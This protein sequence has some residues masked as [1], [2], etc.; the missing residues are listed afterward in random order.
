MGH[1]VTVN[2]A[3]KANTDFTKLLDT[4]MTNGNKRL[5]PIKKQFEEN[6]V[7]F[8]KPYGKNYY[9]FGSGDKWHFSQT[10]E[11]S[12][13]SITNIINGLAQNIALGIPGTGG[14]EKM[15]QDAKEGAKG[16][17][18]TLKGALQ[19]TNV[20]LHIAQLALGVVADV[21]DL[22]DS[23]V[24]G[25][26]GA[27]Y[28]SQHISPGFMLH[29]YSMNAVAQHFTSFNEQNLQENALGY[30]II[31]SLDQIKIEGDIVAAS[32]YLQ[33][34]KDTAAKLI[35]FNKQLGDME[36]KII[37]LEMKGKSAKFLKQALK[38][39]TKFYNER[40]NSFTKYQKELE[41]LKVKQE[42][43]AI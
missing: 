21:L 26:I 30:Q 27:S 41:G 8:Y 9:S 24:A 15:P 14:D 35:S 1:S 38:D 33:E 40:N 43:F 36:Q 25:V 6:I 23:S 31:F 3:I 10:G 7:D 17:I 32:T 29:M 22:F 12:L 11:Y 4:Q 19:L 42:K 16:S 34:I 18:G 2:T 37:N 13:G 5:E 39:A 28:T 20:E